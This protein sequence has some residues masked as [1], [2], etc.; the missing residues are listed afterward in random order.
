M[1]ANLKIVSFTL[2]L[3]L[4]NLDMSYFCKH[5]RSRS[6]GSVLFVIIFA[7]FVIK[8]VNLYQQ[9][10]SNFLIG[11]KLEVGVAS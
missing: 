6:V 3:V 8:Y 9:P 2:N 10:E 7:L 5:C 4:L 1:A 11:S